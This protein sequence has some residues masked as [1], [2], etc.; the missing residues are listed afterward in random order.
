MLVLK[1]A[2]F[3]ALNKIWKFLFFQS[4]KLAYFYNRYYEKVQFLNA[5]GKHE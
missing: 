5:T 4:D 1:E 3:I 2:H